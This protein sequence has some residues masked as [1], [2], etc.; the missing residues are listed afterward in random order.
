MARLEHIGHGEAQGRA[1][2]FAHAATELA[3]A[4]AFLAPLQLEAGK[5]R[6]AVVAQ[7]ATGP[8]WQQG[9]EIAVD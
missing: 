4:E 1:E 9:L 6:F 7:L 8:G 2:L 5:A 3:E